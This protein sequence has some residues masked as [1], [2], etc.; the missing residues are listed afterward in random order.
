MS[1][2]VSVENKE[3]AP[4]RPPLSV[5]RIAGEIL[6][7]TVVGF[8][9][10]LLGG[11]GFLICVLPSATAKDC[12]GGFGALAGAA[13]FVFPA[14]YSL[15]CGVGVYLVGKRGKQTGS[16]LWTLGCGLAGWLV[17]MGMQGIILDL[18]QSYLPLLMALLILPP[19]LATLGFNLT[20][21]YKGPPPSHVARKEHAPQKPPLSVG[22]IAGEILVGAAVG[23]AAGLLAGSGFLVL[24]VDNVLVASFFFVFPT[25]YGAASPV[26][27]YLVGRRGRQ[28]GSLLSTLGCGFAGAMVVMVM[29]NVRHFGVLAVP[30]MPDVAFF[31]LVLLVPPLVATYAF[32]STRR[33]RAAPSP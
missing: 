11:L 3:Q 22:R 5:G 31:A 17:M 21:R 20:R 23:F 12:M 4:Q 14:A 7:G 2:S 8:A 13:F 24:P 9:A 29:H 28:T 27:V 16:F 25:V 26:G 32:N 1:E 6:A 10:G 33:Y 30:R 15:T 18:D 19:I